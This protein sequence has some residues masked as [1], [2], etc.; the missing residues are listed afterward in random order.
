VKVMT[1]ITKIPYQFLSDRVSLSWSEIKFGLEHQ[2]IAPRVAIEEAVNRLQRQ[3]NLLSAEVELVGRSDSDPILELVERLAEAE[4]P[5]PV[6]VKDKWLFLILAWLYENRSSVPDPLGRVEELY[7]D[8]G[9]PNEIAP[10]VRY[11]PM[12]GSDLGDRAANE[13]RLYDYWKSYL[14]IA[15]RRF[16]PSTVTDEAT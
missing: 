16:R 5:P 10:F 15:G 11:M 1:I 13:T 3:S 2:L 8:F 12:V 14:D 6:P 7:S 9:Y 4:G